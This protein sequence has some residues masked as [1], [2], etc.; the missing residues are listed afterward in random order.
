MTKALALAYHT[1][2]MLSFL[3]PNDTTTFKK[4]LKMER[5]RHCIPVRVRDDECMDIDTSGTPSDEPAS[6]VFLNGCLVRGEWVVGDLEGEFFVLILAISAQVLNSLC[7]SS[8][9]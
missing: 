6:F 5:Y 9:A 3:S 8:G 2:F 7:W 4:M 1:E